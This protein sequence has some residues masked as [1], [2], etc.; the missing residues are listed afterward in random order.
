M[1][2]VADRPDVVAL[3]TSFET[4]SVF[5]IVVTPRRI[6][7]V[8]RALPAPLVKRYPIEDAFAHW[9][10]PA[11]S[12]CPGLP[13]TLGSAT[14]CVVWTQPI[15][16]HRLLRR[17]RRSTCRSRSERSSSV[18]SVRTSKLFCSCAPNAHTSPG[19]TRYY[20]SAAPSQTYIDCFGR[21]LHETCG[22]RYYRPPRR[23][24]E[25]SYRKLVLLQMFGTLVEDS[26][27]RRPSTQAARRSEGSSAD[28]RIGA[29][30]GMCATAR[31]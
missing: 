8:E 11:T 10:R 28:Q 22:H 16:K 23:R 19:H 13:R 15:T 4:Q 31:R 1:D 12:T 29:R 26:S 24:A 5:D 3:D 25:R 17:S 18:R 6:E 14:R 27:P 20:R 9:A 30:S 2:R 7:L 21:E